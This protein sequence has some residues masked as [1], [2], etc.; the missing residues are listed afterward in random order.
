MRLHPQIWRFRREMERKRR[1]GFFGSEKD[2]RLKVEDLA[3]VSQ[4]RRQGNVMDHQGEIETVR[5]RNRTREIDE[6]LLLRIRR[7]G[8]A[9]LVV[10]L[11]IIDIILGVFLPTDADEKPSRV[12]FVN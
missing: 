2:G 3:V 10:I 6:P 9:T 1:L 7:I 4:R 5:Q 12:R 11:V 8:G